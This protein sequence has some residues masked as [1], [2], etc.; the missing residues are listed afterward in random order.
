MARKTLSVSK[1]AYDALARMKIIREPFTDVILRLTA[2]G[3]KGTLL[4]HV[5]SLEPD[6]EFAGALERI[7]K[8]RSKLAL[9]S[10]KDY[11]WRVRS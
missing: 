10:L 9:A 6:E 11:S 4:D 1:D 5:K 3:K 8:K 2:V 7:L